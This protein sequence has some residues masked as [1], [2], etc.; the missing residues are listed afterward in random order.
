MTFKTMR[1]EEFPRAVSVDKE[2]RMT[3]DWFLGHSNVKT[4]RKE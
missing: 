2:E 1:L 3:K 4:R